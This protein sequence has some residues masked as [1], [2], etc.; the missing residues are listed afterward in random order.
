VLEASADGFG[1]E[2]TQGTVFFEPGAQNADTFDQ[3]LGS[4]VG[5]TLIAAG[6]V[7]P[8]HAL[9]ALAARA[10]E[11]LP[12]GAKADLE[13]ASYLPKG[14]SSAQ[15]GHQATSFVMGFFSIIKEACP[16]QERNQ[17]RRRNRIRRLLSAR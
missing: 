8:I 15:R 14:G 10:V 4:A 17:S 16:K 3:A 2:L 11:P 6:P 7:L 12:S 1:A 13:A 5:R 9:K